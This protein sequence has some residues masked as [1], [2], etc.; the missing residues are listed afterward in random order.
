MITIEPLNELQIHEYQQERL[1]QFLLTEGTHQFRVLEAYELESK[2]GDP[3]IKVLLVIDHKGQVYKMF[4]YILCTKTW[5]HKL[6]GFCQSI[7]MLEMYESGKIEASS[8]VGKRG[9]AII[10]CKN[11][12]KYGWQNSVESYILAEDKN[13]TANTTSE[14]IDDDVP[15]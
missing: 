2:K 13:N 12:K 1:K 10:G 14:I 9:T 3:M 15:F 11:D 5:M 4:D 8:L 6:R 7:N